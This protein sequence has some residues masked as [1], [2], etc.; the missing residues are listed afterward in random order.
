VEEVR[1]VFLGMGSLMRT[2]F[3]ILFDWFDLK[4]DLI[5]FVAKLSCS[6]YTKNKV[7][8]GWKIKME[9]GKTMSSIMGYF[10]MKVEELNVF[11][12]NAGKTSGCMGIW[13]I[14]VSFKT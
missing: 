13:Y 14:S 6:K 11:S 4:A 7:F 5:S 2:R 10:L 3:V 9:D 12:K 1:L 8:T